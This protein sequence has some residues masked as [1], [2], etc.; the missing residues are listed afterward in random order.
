[1][2]FSIE[3]AL[4]EGMKDPGVFESVV[5]LE[6]D[7]ST[8]RYY[9]ITFSPRFSGLPSVVM[10][11]YPDSHIVDGQLPFLSVHAILK[12]ASVSVPEVYLH[13]PE[14]N[15]VF[16]EDAGDRTLMNLVD[17]RG[18]DEEVFRIYRKT[19]QELIK[20][21][22]LGTELLTPEDLPSR[23]SFDSEK[24]TEEMVFLCEHGI[25]NLFPDKGEELSRTLLSLVSPVIE[26]LVSLP[27][28]LTHRDYH[29]RNIMVTDEGEIRIIDFQ[30]ARMGPLVYDVASLLFDSYVSLPESWRTKLAA[31]YREM[32]RDCSLPVGGT[33]E[34]FLLS[35]GEMAIQR[36]LKALGT[37]YYMSL[38]RGKGKYL[39][40]IPLTISHL[41]G[42]PVLRER[43]PELRN[44]VIPLL[45]RM[46]EEVR[47]DG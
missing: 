20:I 26:N 21:Q 11:R 29:S 24:L 16:L 30:D 17:E 13:I 31:E 33:Q 27:L 8:R 45:E 41:K 36:N 32:A 3:Q 46:W 37:F 14:G 7:A 15:L 28:F 9:R 42:N 23:L 2:T 47:P 22:K 5:E 25:K 6:G 38:V 34:E 44:F 40:S 12:K 4:M 19:L 43:H 35:L 1:M 10:M 18:F 39:P